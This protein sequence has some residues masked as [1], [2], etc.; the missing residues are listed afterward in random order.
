VQGHPCRHCCSTA[1][2]WLSITPHGPGY[3]SWGLWDEDWKEVEGH[4]DL[5]PKVSRGVKK[6]MGIEPDYFVAVAPDPSDEEMVGV[7][8]KLRELTRGGS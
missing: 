4:L 2:G 8:A 6:L 7:W 3:A 5:D 1:P